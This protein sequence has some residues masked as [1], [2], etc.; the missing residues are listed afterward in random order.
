[1]QIKV[2]D[3]EHEKDL[4]YEVNLWLKDIPDDYIINILPT[5]VEE[6]INYLWGSLNRQQKYFKDIIKKYNMKYQKRLFE[7]YNM[8]Y[9]SQ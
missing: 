4:E 8:Y 2:I 5:E 7:L 1:M 9:I 3:C 6:N